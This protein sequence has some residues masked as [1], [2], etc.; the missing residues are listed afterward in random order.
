MT[1]IK[2]ISRAVEM[3]PEIEKAFAN[4]IKTCNGAITKNRSLYLSEE[5][6]TLDKDVDR[7]LRKCSQLDSGLANA[8]MLIFGRPNLDNL[9]YTRLDVLDP[10]DQGLIRE[11]HVMFNED[12]L[13]EA[14]TLGEKI[15]EEKNVPGVKG[16]LFEGMN[17]IKSH[18]QEFRPIWREYQDHAEP[19]DEN[20]KR[21]P[22]GKMESTLAYNRRTLMA[23]NEEIVMGE[24]K[25][26]RLRN[27][28]KRI[29]EENAKLEGLLGT[30]IVETREE[31]EEVVGGKLLHL[32]Q[33]PGRPAAVPEGIEISPAG[34]Q[35]VADFTL[36]MGV[37]ENTDMAKGKVIPIKKGTA[38]E[39]VPDDIA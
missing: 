35:L 24:D 10:K 14:I 21:L 5:S 32:P 15:L 13:S 2:K 12:K 37:T 33:K 28:T 36:G 16:V 1:E 26:K 11:L 4:L 29:Q 18:L 7:E 31:A 38:K 8:I 19:L 17:K 25:L 22:R 6:S 27:R 3:S 9:D 23:L 20:G 30:T 39:D 34:E